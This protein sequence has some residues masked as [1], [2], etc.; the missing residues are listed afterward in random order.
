[1]FVLSLYCLVD[2][3]NVVLFLWYKGSTT[4][5]VERGEGFSVVFKR[6]WNN[7]SGWEWVFYLMHVV[8]SKSTWKVFSNASLDRVI[9]ECMFCISAGTC[10]LATGNKGVLLEWIHVNKK[11][12]NSLK[13]TI[14]L[15]FSVKIGHFWV[16]Q[17]T[18]ICASLTDLIVPNRHYFRQFVWSM[19]LARS[20]CL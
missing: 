7:S 5:F 3:C 17:F 6:L 8:F 11:A 10:S 12:L 9:P 19:C 2:C 14:G 1:M 15:F 18:F 4:L 20:A 16:W 13:C